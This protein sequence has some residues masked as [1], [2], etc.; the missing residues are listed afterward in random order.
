MFGVLVLSVWIHER[1]F[2]QYQ[3]G[4]SWMLDVVQQSGF[5][6][7]VEPVALNKLSCVNKAVACQPVR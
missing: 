4:V 1:S 6:H 2:K 7:L 5:Y 3:I